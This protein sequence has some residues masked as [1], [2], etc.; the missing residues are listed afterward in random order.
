L[1]LLTY[2]WPNSRYLV[3]FL[4]I[5]RKRIIF[6]IYFLKVRVVT[7][8]YNKKVVRSTENCAKHFILIH[9]HTYIYNVISKSCDYKYRFQS[10]D[11]ACDS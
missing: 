10:C 5:F 6:K 8:G 7:I 2:L 4:G 11:K 1:G 9:N 3:H